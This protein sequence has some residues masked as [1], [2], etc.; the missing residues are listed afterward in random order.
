RGATLLAAVGAASTVRLGHE[1][2]DGAVRA[3]LLTFEP[4]PKE[5]TATEAVSE[6]VIPAGGR[7]ELSI[8]VT[9]SEH[10]PDPGEPLSL[11]EIVRR[12]QE[13]QRRRSGDG[14]RIATAHEGLSGWLRRSRG[15]LHMLVTAT[16]AGLIPHA[17]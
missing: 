7:F 14:A 1:G 11:P 15:D 9:T 6:L 2:L 4:A 3:T 10:A 16:S 17:A 13:E 12:R 5:L 8:G